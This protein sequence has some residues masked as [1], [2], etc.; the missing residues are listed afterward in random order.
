MPMDSG[1]CYAAKLMFYFDDSIAECRPFTYGGCQGNANKF[2]TQDACYRE[3]GEQGRE[4]RLITPG[5]VRGLKSVNSR[6]GLS[7][8]THAYTQQSTLHNNYF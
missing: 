2:D 8:Q 7:A 4:Y 3:C 5:G 1:P 6:I